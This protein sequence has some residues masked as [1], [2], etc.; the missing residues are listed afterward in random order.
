MTTLN[1]ARPSVTC[2]QERQTGPVPLSCC[3]YPTLEERGGDE[4]CQVC[5]WEDD[6]LGDQDAGEVKGGSN[7]ELSLT[8]ARSNFDRIGAER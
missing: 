3:G 4:T 8:E 7:Y 1:T 5:F 6:G 2:K